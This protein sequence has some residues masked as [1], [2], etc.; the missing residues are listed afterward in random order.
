MDRPIREHNSRFAVSFPVLFSLTCCICLSCAFSAPVIPPNSALSEQ[1]ALVFRSLAVETGN[2]SLRLPVFPSGGIST[3]KKSYLEAETRRLTQFFLTGLNSPPGDLWVNL[4]VREPDRIAGASL[5]GTE[6]GRIMLEADIQLKKDFSGLLSPYTSRG[7]N[8]WVRVRMKAD[9]L[10]GEGQAGIPLE[11]RLWI[12]PE[13]VVIK[14]S[15]ESAFIEKASLKVSCEPVFEQ[16]TDERI[17][18][19]GRYAGALLRPLLDEELKNRVNT[20]GSYSRLRQVFYSLVLAQWFKQRS[21]SGAVYDELAARG[22]LAGLLSGERW[23]GQ[24][25]FKQYRRLTRKNA[26]GFSS[27]S[28]RSTGDICVRTYFSGGIS[29][30][31]PSLAVPPGAPLPFT[32]GAVTVERAAGGE[33]DELYKAV[34]EARISKGGSSVPELG[35]VFNSFPSGGQNEEGFFV[36]GRRNPDGGAAVRGNGNTPVGIEKRDFS[37]TG[38]GTGRGE[39]LE[40]LL[41]SWADMLDASQG[42][43]FSPAVRR[44]TLN[45]A[46]QCV[47]LFPFEPEHSASDPEGLASAVYVIVDLLRENI[48]RLDLPPGTGAVVDP[49]EIAAEREE[50]LTIMEYFVQYEY[51]LNFVVNIPKIEPYRLSGSGS[52]SRFVERLVRKAF[53]FEYGL[54]ESRERLLRMTDVIINLGNRLVNSYA[55]KENAVREKW[56]RWIIEQSKQGNG[57][58]EIKAGDGPVLRKRE[59]QLGINKTWKTAGTLARFVS[60]VS[61]VMF[62]LVSLLDPGH[63]FSNIWLFLFKLGLILFSFFVSWY[64]VVYVGFNDGWY[65]KQM[66]VIEELRAVSGPRPDFRKERAR[67]EFMKTAAEFRKE[68][69]SPSA[70][71]IFVVCGKGKEQD[72]RRQLSRGLARNDVFLKVIESGSGSAAAYAEICS[73]LTSGEYTS[74]LQKIARLKDKKAVEMRGMV[75]FCEDISSL[76]PAAEF[77][78]KIGI[79]NSSFP[80]RPQNSLEM[81]L[82]NGYRATREMEKE[83]R[84][85]MA[86]VFADGLF[87]GPLEITGDIT[88]IGAWTSFGRIE[89]EGLGLL[90][91]DIGGD[92][93]VIKLFEKTS[94]GRLQKKLRK[95]PFYSALKRENKGMN[96][97]IGFTGIS[98]ISFK[99]GTRYERFLKLAADAGV[100]MKERSGS[101]SRYPF[102]REILIPLIMTV[103]GENP[104]S[105]LDAR[106]KEREFG[107][108]NELAG[109]YEVR[110]SI[111][112]RIYSEK[113]SF[114]PTVRICAGPGAVFLKPAGKAAAADTWS[115][116]G[117]P[118]DLKTE[119]LEHLLPVW[120]GLLDKTAGGALNNEMR[121]D[122]MNICGQCVVL[123]P[124][125]RERIGGR[126][127]NLAADI[128]IMADLIKRSIAAFDNLAEQVKEGEREDVLSERKELLTALEYFTHYEYALNFVVNITKI[129]PYRFKREGQ[130]ALKL[131]W[132]VRKIFSF[133]KGLRKSKEQFFRQLQVV[134]ELGDRMNG[135][136]AGREGFLKDEWKEWIDGSSS[137]GRPVDRTRSSVPLYAQTGNCGQ[138]V[139]H[140]PNVQLG[141][142]RIWDSDRGTTTRLLSLVSLLLFA[143]LTFLPPLLSS[144]LPAAWAAAG[145]FLH[146]PLSALAV[147]Y[148]NGTL[149]PVFLTFLRFSLGV[150]PLIFSWY[151]L[152][153]VSVKDAWYEERLKDIR[154]LQTA[155][156]GLSPGNGGKTAAGR[157]IAVEYGRIFDAYFKEMTDKEPSVDFIVV[158]GSGDFGRKTGI[159]PGKMPVRDEGVVFKYLA[160]EDTGRSGNAWFAVNEYLLSGFEKDKQKCRRLAD[161]K[162]TEMRGIVIF[163]ADSFRELPFPVPESVKNKLKRSYITNLDLAVLNGYKAAQQMKERSRCGLSWMFG[164]SLFIGPF[165]ITGDITLAG[166]WTDYEQLHSQKPGLLIADIGNGGRLRKIYEKADLR[167]VREKLEQ[168]AFYTALDW[169]ETKRKQML[170]FSGITLFSFREETRYAAFLEL[171]AEAC[172][173][174]GKKENSGYKL[175]FV[176]DFLNP[177]LMLMNDNNPYT[178]LD[179]RFIDEK[180]GF[181][182]EEAEYSFRRRM[183]GIYESYKD[184]LPAFMNVNVHPHGTYLKLQNSPFSAEGLER[185]AGAL[186]D[187]KGTGALREKETAKIFLEKEAGKTF[188]KYYKKDA[189]FRA[190]KS[191]TGGALTASAALAAADLIGATAFKPR[192][193]MRGDSVRFSTLIPGKQQ[194]WDM[195]VEGFLWN[196]NRLKNVLHERQTGGILRGFDCHPPLSNGYYGFSPSSGAATAYG[197]SRFSDGEGRLGGRTHFLVE[198]AGSIEADGGSGHRTS[199]SRPG[200]LQGINAGGNGVDPGGFIS[201]DVGNSSQRGR[202]GGSQSNPGGKTAGSPQAEDPGLSVPAAAAGKSSLPDEGEECVYN[203]WAKA[204]DGG[205]AFMLSGG[206]A[207]VSAF[208]GGAIEKALQALSDAGKDASGYNFFLVNSCDPSNRID[209]TPQMYAAAGSACLSHGDYKKALVYYDL[210]LLSYGTGGLSNRLYEEITAGRGKAE[211]MLNADS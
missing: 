77:L 141:I 79:G 69:N 159:S 47:A 8:F 70:D 154:E 45:I 72:I 36:Y 153:F 102:T 176:P 163:T 147:A 118:D 21:P 112:N 110:R 108:G 7:S 109:E 113:N 140:K 174:A 139:L 10:F 9:E 54:K 165:N 35:L 124:F 199:V 111:V 90:F 201:L 20:S 67:A 138:R 209:V 190:A 96:Q 152:S 149:W 91:A 63:I 92:N 64:S 200:V 51:G 107:G 169:N 94:G 99:D 62:L 38:Y 136:Y 33:I 16:G 164:D 80:G 11:I 126:P 46:S 128:Y 19:L 172:V 189:V 151:N 71:Y 207:G 73:S 181:A 167:K 196:R 86:V 188:E 175:Y 28:F 24:D 155:S 208:S 185:I 135:L 85:G 39:Y 78:D 58:E 55:G 194:S 57:A 84:S 198:A 5:H 89:N 131:S 168:E 31:L 150:I 13:E 95:T 74:E 120:A 82:L 205:E 157:Y 184:V 177:L 34:V 49:G 1:P 98:V 6:A 144:G 173:Y 41:R 134:I 186:R 132:L 142:N 195:N 129:E 156:S 115:V 4:S 171:M 183:N 15:G 44:D 83:D 161:K 61:V 104:Y 101:H 37:A 53:L 18:I 32:A 178:Y 66:S 210:C 76:C 2:E 105:Y 17:V 123:T 187:Y 180:G 27:V 204:K 42:K 26:A 127:E 122:I 193:L 211:E 29:F 93:R 197:N 97:L 30:F 52:H 162:I 22:V 148:V 145:G 206:F 3:Y 143:V 114:K 117:R 146:A 160:L 202:I 166:A 68:I 56:R 50:L 25:Y 88:L 81:A 130:L 191:G 60:L 121:N 75:L 103:N 119:K 48:R 23:S 87:S 125:T 40:G 59:V 43:A 116:D 12:E 182:M 158:I 65:D 203:L 192:L 100:F 14:E 106:C 170:V 137:G 179:A 133:E